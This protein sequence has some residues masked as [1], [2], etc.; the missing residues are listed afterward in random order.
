MARELG[1]GELLMRDLLQG[2]SRPCRDP[3]DDLSPP[4]LRKGVLKLDDLKPGMELSG[5]VLNVVDFGAFVDIGISDSALVHI[6]RLADHFI[7]DPHDVVS[8]GDV[9]RVWVVSIDRERR[10]VALTAIPP[11]QSRK[12]APAKEPAS[13]R[14]RAPRPQAAPAN[15]PARGNQSPPAPNAARPK[16]QKPR[17][18]PKPKVVKPITQAMADGREP[19]RSFSDLVQFYQKKQKPDGDK[20]AKS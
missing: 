19:L 18:A 2:L 6:S 4:L 12:G 5:T 9:M 1:I 14:S 17:P 15:S 16:Q 13:G 7:R 11:G 20:P 8:V 3:R 10:R